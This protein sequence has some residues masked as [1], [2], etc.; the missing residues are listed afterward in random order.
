[1][2][3]TEVNCLAFAAIFNRAWFF[4]NISSIQQAN[5]KRKSSKATSRGIRRFTSI[6]SAV[7][8]ATEVA[9]FLNN[10]I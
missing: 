9:D 7:L 1:M 4:K 6:A 2:L 5:A 8:E 10:E 3:T